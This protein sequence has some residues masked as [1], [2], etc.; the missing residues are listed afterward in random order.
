[1]KKRIIIC[2]LLALTACTNPSKKGAWNEVD[3]TEA[4]KDVKEFSN[5]LETVGTARNLC[6]DCYIDSLEKAYDNYAAAK[7]LNED[8]RLNILL[9]CA[10]RYMHFD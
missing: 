9:D 2:T 4:M 3:R 8:D 7:K 6:Y 1:M 10:I 5:A